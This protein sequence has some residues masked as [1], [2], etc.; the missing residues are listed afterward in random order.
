MVPLRPAPAP[1]FRQICVLA[2]VAG[3]WASYALIPGLTAAVLVWIAVGTLPRARLAAFLVCVLAGA[4]LGLATRPGP[5]PTPPGWF[6][7]GASVRLQGRVTE[8]SGQPDRRLRVLLEDVRP[9]GVPAAAPLPGRVN[10]TWDRNKSAPG[11][12]PLPGQTVGLTAKLRPI[13]GFA[14]EGV[15]DSSAYWAAR[16]VGFSAWTYGDQ[17]QVTL[18]GPGDAAAALRER[19]RSTL[20]T[21]LAPAASPGPEAG[22]ETPP[23]A[24][25]ILPALLFG[26]RHGLD[27][28]TLD[29]FIRA[30]LVH[31]LALSGQ[32]LALAATAAVLLVWLLSRG[33]A[34]VLLRLPRRSLLLIAAAPPAAL[35]L[36][37]GGAPP[38][39]VRAA[40]MLL[41]GALFCLTRRT[42][43]PADPLFFAALCL[44][45]V[46]PQSV[47]DL[48]VQL[49][50]LSVAGIMAALPW[51]RPSVPA[52]TPLGRA[53]QGALTLLVASLAAQ[54][55][56]LPI[57]LHTFGR[58]T[59]LFPLNLL[60]LPLLE[61]V[62]LPVAALGTVLLTALGPQPVS[63]VLLGLAALPGQGLIATLEWL[64]EHGWLVVEQ[65]LRPLP[66]AALGYA[67]AGA[68]FVC[69]SGRRGAE[70]CAARRLALAAAF[71]LPLG[72]VVRETQDWRVRREQRVT[73][74]VLDV[75]QSQALTL[76]W[77]GGRLLLDGGGSLSPR[78]D[79]GRDVVAPALTVNRPPRL[80]MVLA[81]HAD[82]DHVRGLIAILETFDV[83]S[84]GRSAL[85]FIRDNNG[86]DSDA[87]RLEALRLRRRVPLREFRAGDLLDLGGG[88]SLDIIHPPERGRFSSNNGSLVVRITLRG[89][90]LALLCGDAQKPAL[91][92]ILKSGA[93]L[94]ADVLV[95]PHHGSATSLS[96][97]FYDAVSPRVALISCGAY[98]SFGFPWPEVLNALAERGIPALTT[99]SYG[100]LR[101]TWRGADR[102]APIGPILTVFRPHFRS[103][104]L[105]PTP[106]ASLALPDDAD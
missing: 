17:G 46:W 85:P 93:D 94:R 16:N 52:R 13:S 68:A 103:L 86:N 40:L 4:G 78:F 10:W 104:G 74:R 88:L 59:P 54:L 89:H 14:N 9:E 25:A 97:E 81:S 49:S 56:T 60:W 61:L 38:S 51:L 55:A 69:L 62:V 19:W 34:A 106:I 41:G 30:G 18:S 31:S 6:E 102:S 76:E 75:G 7:A 82:L 70:S 91:S 99:A 98:N 24:R 48:S 42:R 57:T 44:L 72:A 92:R 66:L 27:S 37:V 100:E 71:L 67:A 105:A 77:P 53:G 23:Q 63:D 36:W 65:G 39:L 80:N 35:Y 101:V 15:G 2:A 45:I 28:A 12:R 33:R 21:A 32:H 96:P 84:F 58:L 5:P 26:D 73:L 87:A 3:V 95:L 47:F 8:V 50:V 79:P 64:R 83:K 43:A 29:M 90:G 20:E 1:L 11:P 22:A